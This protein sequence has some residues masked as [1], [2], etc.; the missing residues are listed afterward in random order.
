MPHARRAAVREVIDE[1]EQTDPQS[2][3]SIGSHPFG[4]VF[5]RLI[6][7]PRSR[8]GKDMGRVPPARDVRT[9]RRACGGSPVRAQGRRLKGHH[10]QKATEWLD[11]VQVPRRAES[12]APPARSRD[13]TSLT[14]LKA[15]RS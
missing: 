2:V 4:A 7:D 6:V 15:G 9:L 13:G 3:V 11:A 12:T 5:A 8:I 14:H 1:P 10:A